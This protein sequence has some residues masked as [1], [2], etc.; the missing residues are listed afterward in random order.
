MNYALGCAF[1]Q[2]ELFENFPYKK[3][4]ISCKECKKITGDLHRDTLVK[5][6]FRESIKLVLDDIIKNNVTFELPLKGNKKCNI[7]MQR[8]RGEQFKAM[9]RAGK[10]R[11]INYLKSLFTGYQL[12]FYML[13]NRTPRVKNI[14][15]NK[16]YRDLIVKNTNSGMQYGDGKINTTIKDYYDKIFELFPSVSEKDIKLILDFSWKSLYLHNSYGGDT[17]VSD[18]DLWCY[19]GR[20]KKDPLKHFQY[21]IKKLIIRLRV[22]YRRRKT[23][24]DGYYYFGLTESAYQNYLKQKNGKGR[25][26]KRFNYGQVFMYQ[27]LDECKIAE[28]SS[29]YIF[30]IPYITKVNFKFYV[31]E[32]I[33]DKAELIITREPLKFKDILTYNNNYEIL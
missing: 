3:L 17:L 12:G 30:R 10:W 29:K 28:N 22:L 7:H 23:D 32:L 27:L 19:I 14:Y 2:D 20:L 31:Q 15:V 26:K 1:S 13:G 11:D 18:N 5:R 8:I 24:W 16:Y 25:P 9:R 21:Y 33:T 4:K 6:I